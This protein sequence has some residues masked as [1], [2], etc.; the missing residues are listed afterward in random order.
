M[1]SRASKMQKFTGICIVVLCLCLP[2]LHQVEAADSDV[3]YSGVEQPHTSLYA[4]SPEASDNSTDPDYT[5]AS[6]A[7]A[8]L[9]SKYAAF[10]GNPAGGIQT[11]TYGL[12]GNYYTQWFDN[13]MALMAWV[14]GYVYWYYNS[15]WQGLTTVWSA[16]IA[17]VYLIFNTLLYQYSSFFGTPAGG[18]IH[19]T[20][21]GQDYFAMYFANGIV[22]FAA[23]DGFL[24]YYLGGTWKA[25]GMTWT[26]TS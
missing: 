25:I 24:Y 9:M 5:A 14:D 20:I 3:S 11:N 13:G 26:T 8:S 1:K 4:G 10:F 19:G 2:V 12:G 23:P 7:I 18:M 16:K 15:T 21:N 22:L 17:N 6:T